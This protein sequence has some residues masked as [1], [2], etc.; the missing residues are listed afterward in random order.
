M[1]PAVLSRW[2]EKV[3]ELTFSFLAKDFFQNNPFILPDFT[4]YAAKQATHSNNKFLIDAY[5]GSGLFALSLAKHFDKVKGIEVS[6]TSTSWAHQNAKL[7]NIDNTEFIAASAEAI[8]KSIDFPA[9]QTTVV[10][11]PPRAGCSQEFLDQ[12]FNYAPNTC[13]YISCEPATQMRDLK[14]FLE[15]GY[16]IKDIQPFDLFPQ[17]RHLECIVTLTKD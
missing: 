14:Y 16:K 10:I 1:S 8:F 7:N 4:D 6:E 9:K 17:T 11:D 12:L 3:G 5:C 15:S 2:S 13:V